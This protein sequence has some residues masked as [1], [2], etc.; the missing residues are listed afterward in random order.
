MNIPQSIPPIQANE[1]AEERRG[2]L[3]VGILE[4]PV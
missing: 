4:Y 3:Q 1:Q 2:G